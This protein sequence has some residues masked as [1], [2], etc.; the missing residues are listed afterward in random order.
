MEALQNGKTRNYYNIAEFLDSLSSPLEVE[1][2]TVEGK[3]VEIVA[4]ADNV[5]L[6]K[7]FLSTVKAKQ[8]LNE[9]TKFSLSEHDIRT[10]YLNGGKVDRVVFKGKIY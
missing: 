10:V 6:I 2:I 1:S 8:V 3:N 5:A 9:F 7:Q 4:Y